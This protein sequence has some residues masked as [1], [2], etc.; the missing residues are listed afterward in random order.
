VYSIIN[1]IYG[2]PL[3]SNG[4]GDDNNDPPQTEALY[5]DIDDEGDP[6]EAEVYA[7]LPPGEG[8]SIHYPTELHKGVLSYYLGSAG[9]SPLAFGVE[10]G[11][12][13]A[14]THHTDLETLPLVATPEQ[15]DHFNDIYQKLDIDSKLIV[16]HFGP[17]R[18]F[19]LWSSS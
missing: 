9:D 14:C 18:V 7:T 19:F 11:E 1:V 5:P 13:D 4:V 3:R 8:R 2:V 17:P 16:D 6:P 12:F 15:I 10:L